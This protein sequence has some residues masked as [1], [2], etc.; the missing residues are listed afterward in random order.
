MPADSSLGL[1]VRTTAHDGMTLL[2]VEGVLDSSTYSTLRDHVIKAAL[3]EPAAV[4]VEVSALHASSESAWVVFTSARW[5]VCN[6]P[7]VPIMLV[8]DDGACRSAIARNGVS[9]YVP[10]HPSVAAAVDA[11]S[12]CAR[13]YRRRARATLIAAPHSVR[14]SRQLVEG[15]LTAWSRSELIGVAKVI[16]TSLV[17]NVLAHTD[18]P[19]GLRVESRGD[20]VTVAVED[21]NRSRPAHSEARMTTDDQT[22]LRMVGALCRVWGT[23]P[24]PSG[25]TVWAVIG[26]ENRL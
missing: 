26:P 8:C 21:D 4:L 14:Q 15:W 9:R 24:T 5:H 11:L 6:W 17:E 18:G 19:P 13:T 7:E 25:K 22:G 23:A 12:D 16:V 20:T 2:V 3:E 1:S 10:V